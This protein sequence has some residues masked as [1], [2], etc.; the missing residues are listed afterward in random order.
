MKF[1]RNV[2]KTIHKSSHLHFFSSASQCL[3][4][5]NFTTHYIYKISILSRCRTRIS[6]TKKPPLKNEAKFLFHFYGMRQ[7][8]LRFVALR[9]PSLCVFFYLLTTFWRLERGFHNWHKEQRA[10]WDKVREMTNSL[11]GC[12]RYTQSHFHPSSMFVI[13]TRIEIN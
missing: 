7:L 2:P 12:E 11:S 1:E 9:I 13:P 8:T 4:I 5:N 3:F 6:R 10:E